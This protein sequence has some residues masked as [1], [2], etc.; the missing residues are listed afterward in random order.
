MLS[1]QHSKRDKAYYIIWFLMWNAHQFHL[2]AAFVSAE[3]PTIICSVFSMPKFNAQQDSSIHLVRSGMQ[4]HYECYLRNFAYRLPDDTF[5]VEGPLKTFSRCPNAITESRLYHPIQP[6][7][8]PFRTPLVQSQVIRCAHKS[9]SIT[10][11]L[12]EYQT[13]CLTITNIHSIDVI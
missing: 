11:H 10:I 6:V 4:N 7:C 12:I 5:T 8:N 9:N 3:P 2:P 13:K 1:N